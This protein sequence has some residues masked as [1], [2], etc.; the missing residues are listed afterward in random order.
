MRYPSGLPAAFAL[1]TA[2]V[3]AAAPARAD[4]ASILSTDREA[5]EA[6]AELV[7]GAR[8]E[9]LASYFIVGDDPFSLTS[10]ALLRDAARRGLTVKL[11]VD[12]QWNGIPREV[13]AHLLDEGVEIR[14]Y[15]PWRWRKLH[16]VSRR[17]HD[18][19][20]IVDGRHLIAGGRNVASTY[21]GLGHQ[22]QARNYVDCDLRVEGE[23]AADARRYYEALWASREVRRSR[24]W[25]MPT[26]KRK[27]E[28]RLDGYRDW[29]DGRVAEVR[30]DPGRAVEAPY[31]VGPVRFLH[32]PIG[33]KGQARGVG[34]DLL[35]LL[36]CARHSAVIESPYLVPSRALR[37]SLSRALARG[38]SVR[39][40]TNSLASTDNLF[41]QS[42]YVGK[43]KGLVAAGVELWEYRGP[44]CLH[45]KAAV[46]D[47]ETV[48]VGSFNLDPRSEFL[49][50]EV[51]LAA[52]DKSLAAVLTAIMD[53]NLEKAVRIDARGYPEGANERHP[54]VSRGKI[55]RLSLLRLL[56]PLIERQL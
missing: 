8:S 39:I 54:G 26:D 56:A 53:R 47:G 35:D 1:A 41:P 7:L 5:A 42:G 46:F 4:R 17:M 31:E 12:A 13:E 15:H 49:N 28:I 30:A 51:A 43:K 27:A 36:E 38:V 25:A 21:F 40:L 34:H 19:L 3:L 32:D 23:A 9:I 45:T 29:L 14:E 22:I 18:K 55:W 33:R 50:T 48:L 24:A 37:R 6:R 52:R 16:W 20:L 11:M 44:D 2:L 10:L